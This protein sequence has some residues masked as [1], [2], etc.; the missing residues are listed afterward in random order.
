MFLPRPS[1]HKDIQIDV[2]MVGWTDG[3]MDRP[4]DRQTERWADGQ[5][6]GKTFVII[7]MIWYL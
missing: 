3:R 1:W 4:T 2:K 5:T 6:D 7:K